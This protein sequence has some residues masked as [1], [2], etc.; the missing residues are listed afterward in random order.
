[1]HYKKY[2]IIVAAGSGTRMNSSIPKQ[3]LELNGLP[4]LMHTVNAFYR[5]S[6]NIQIILVLPPND[7]LL[8]KDMCRRYL[9]NAPLSIA[10]GGASRY[11]SV[12]NGLAL[13]EDENAIV[14][15]HDGVR[16]CVTPDLILKSFKIARLKGNAVTAVDLKD[17][18]RMISDGEN[19]SVNR[20]DYKLIQ[21]PQT[22]IFSM[23]QKAYQHDAADHDNFTDD[24]SVMEAMGESIN[25]IEGDQRNIKITTRED[26]YIASSFLGKIN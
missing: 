15:I 11:Q 10:E 25:L 9:F 23:L 12:K 17:S 14:A 26:L 18:I 5:A 20:S 21:T 7:I 24:A 2:A 8:W 3:Y 13:V 22:F 4:I 1:M 19:R 6:S 16:P